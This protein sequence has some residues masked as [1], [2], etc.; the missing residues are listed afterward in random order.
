MRAIFCVAVLAL[1]GCGT[2]LGFDDVRQCEGAECTGGGEDPDAGDAP[3]CDGPEDCS[4]DQPICDG[5][6]GTCRGCTEHAECAAIGDDAPGCSADGSCVECVLDAH[7]AS[8]VCDTGEETCVPEEDV[9]YMAPDGSTDA[10][11]GTH[12][13][14]CK[15]FVEALAQV[16]APRDIV[17]VNP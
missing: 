7:C 1:G 16:A 5:E 2:I 15:R 12:D 13:E 3:A 6:S 17:K 11:C 9:V 8:E 4:G 14:P 10:G